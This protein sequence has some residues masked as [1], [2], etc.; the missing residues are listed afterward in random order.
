MGVTRI[1]ANL[2]APDPAAL[3]QFY[4]D[5]FDLDIPLDMEWITFLTN[6]ATQK[7][8]LHTASEGGSGTDLPVISIG[9]MIWT[10]RRPPCGLLARRWFT[11]L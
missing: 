1:V 9:L 5:V 8:E 10:Q 6:G 3:A 4:K 2:F 7:I 11:V